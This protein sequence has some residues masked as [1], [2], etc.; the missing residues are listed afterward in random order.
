MIEKGYWE[1][2]TYNDLQ[3][4]DYIRF[5]AYSHIVMITAHDGTTYRY[6]GHTNDKLHYAIA[7]NSNSNLIYYSVK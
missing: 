6:S 1:T 2:V 4:G 5:T 3:V 7:I